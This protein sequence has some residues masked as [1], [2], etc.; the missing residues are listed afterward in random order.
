MSKELRH[1]RPYFWSEI[2]TYH[3]PSNVMY[4]FLQ[5][6]DHV[7]S[8]IITQHILINVMLHIIILYL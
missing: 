6:S 4:M 5:H 7:L 2:K 3:V 8:S 1:C